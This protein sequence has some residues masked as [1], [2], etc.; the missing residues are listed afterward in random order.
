MRPRTLSVGLLAP[1]WVAVP[2]PAYG[3]TESVVSELARGLVAEGHDVVLYATGD[4]TA[5][6]P[7]LYALE[8]GAWDRV[9][10]GVVELPHVMRGYEALAGCDIVHDH[11]LLGPAWALACGHKRVVTTCH[12]PFDGELRAIYGRYGKQMPVIAISR[13]QAASAPE[14]AVD[15]VIHHGIDP[16]RYPVG[17]G[18]GGYLLFL[19]RMT[20]DKGVRE[21]VAIAR[22][23]GQHL[24][25]AAKARE[26]AEQRYYAE[27]IEPLLDDRVHYVGEVAGEIKLALLGGA[28]A[29][30]NPIQWAEPFG[31]VMIEALA[32]GTPVV[33]CPNGAA[34]EIVDDGRT[35]FLCTE[36]A[37]LVEAIHHIPELNRAACRAAVFDRFST[38]RMV[39]DH[40]SAYR[41]LLAQ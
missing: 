27:E 13:N 36:F 6:V 16:D 23:A 31:L 11:T 21:A 34:P 1:P 24:V 40:I 32:C 35:G 7:V 9:G 14:I 39:A 19:G 20:P 18:D 25:I 8:T 30:L 3:G 12:G 4:S 38:S 41:D 22:A 37:A 5:P 28:S 10:E 17:R 2:P 15:R 29:L 33:G 26:V